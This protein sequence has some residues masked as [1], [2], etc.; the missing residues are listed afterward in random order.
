M[1]DPLQPKP[2]LQDRLHEVPWM[3]P[4]TARL[5]GTGPVQPGDWLR[6]DEAY[7]GQMALRDRLIAKRGGAVHAL[8]PDAKTP[9]REL[10]ALVLADLT[11]RAGFQ[12]ENE[13]VTRPDGQTITIDFNAPLLTLGRLMQQDFC[14]LQRHEDEHILTGAILCFPASWT[15][16]EKI[17]RP[18][19]AIHAPVSEYTQDMARR[20]QRL[21][22]AVRVE[23]PLWRVNLLLY[24]DAALHQPR[25]VGDDRITNDRDAPFVRSERQCIS[26]LP[27]TGAIVFAIHTVVV[28]VNSLP[29]DVRAQMMRHLDGAL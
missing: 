11:K 12:V 9:A 24:Q 4:S 14:I 17:A 28:R 25:R 21:F 19:S 15:L 3:R 16:A 5:P 2:I 13:R 10:L 22:D 7:A 18:L 20:V 23:T 8:L 26:R 1:I 27:K 29:G 6:V